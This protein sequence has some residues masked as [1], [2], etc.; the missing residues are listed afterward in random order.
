MDLHFPLCFDFINDIDLLRV[1]NEHIMRNRNVKSSIRGMSSVSRF[2]NL[3][4]L[5]WLVDLLRYGISG[6][7]LKQLE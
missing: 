6:S 4:C 5:C 2:G 1:L 3:K 7:D